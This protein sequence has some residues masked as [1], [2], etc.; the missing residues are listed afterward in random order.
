VL[1]IVFFS[2]AYCWGALGH[3]AI[4]EVAYSLLSERAKQGVIHYLGSTTLQSICMI[5]DDYRN[6]NQGR[7]TAP[8][9]YVNF[10]RTAVR[11][12]PTDCPNPPGCVVSAVTNYTSILTREG[13]RGPFCTSATNRTQEPCALIFLTHFIGDIHQPMHAGYADDSGGNGQAVV[14]Y[15]RNTNLHSLWDTGM[16]QN[17][18]LSTTN[19]KNLADRIKFEISN[20]SAMTN[21]YVRNMDPVT[22]V[23]ES[24]AFVR[25]Q[26][27]VFSQSELN[28]QKPFIS[29][30]DPVLGDWYYNRN[31]GTVVARCVAATVRFAAF[32]EDVFGRNQGKNTLQLFRYLS[33]KKQEI[34]KKI[35]SSKFHLNGSKKEKE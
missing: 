28:N 14:Y 1:L 12:Y 15:G 3:G 34:A 24:F 4:S 7:W 33:E 9:H 17:I 10:A 30:A 19:Y 27:Y 32:L 20:N 6:L 21:Y 18:T 31:I 23:D 26:C 25:N 35:N 8:L 5:P 2:S 29:A 22:W 11:Y 16:I 13:T